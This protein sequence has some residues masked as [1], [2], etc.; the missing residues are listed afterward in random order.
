LKTLDPPSE[1][2]LWQASNEKARDFRLQTIGPS[3]K[4]TVVTAQ[5]NGAYV[6]RPALAKMGWTAYFVELTFP[7]GGKYPFKF[8][9]DVRVMPDIYPFPP[10][11]LHKPE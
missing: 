2:R 9:T 6:A 4:S 10:P 5:E 1:V 8:S 3:Y 7:S 11:E